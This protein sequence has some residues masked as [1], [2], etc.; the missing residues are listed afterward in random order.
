MNWASTAASGVSSGQQSKSL[1]EIQAEEAAKER[2]RQEREKQQKRARQKE[3]G[4]AQASVWG[5]ASANLSWAS[6][7]ATAAAAPTPSAAAAMAA[8]PSP[9]AR[10]KQQQ[11]Q[12]H[13]SHH[14]SWNGSAAAAASDGFWDEA[15]VPGLH[16]SAA[17]AAQNTAGQ[18]K[19]KK[20]AQNK[21]AKEDAKVAAIFRE[22][23]KPVNE[24]EAWC[25]QALQNL[26]AQIDIPTFMA[27]LN[28]IESP[29]EVSRLASSLISS[30]VTKFQRSETPFMT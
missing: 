30:H 4:L 10:A 25:T 9:K 19:K 14:R 13:E 21:K 12:Q 20:N 11:Q 18:G 5:S 8:N 1:A 7:A 29:Y 17:A 6:K 24:F 28:D 16:P 27:F 22:Q 3:M 2:E 26:H 23:K 15:P